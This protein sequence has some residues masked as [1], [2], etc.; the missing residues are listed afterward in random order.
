MKQLTTNSPFVF[1]GW[2]DEPLKAVKIQI[3]AGGH[4]RK[5]KGVTLL[6]LSCVNSEL[7]LYN[8]RRTRLISL[9]FYAL[10][11]QCCSFYTCFSQILNLRP[12]GQTATKPEPLFEVSFP[13]ENRSQFNFWMSWSHFFVCQPNPIQF[14]FLFPLILQLRS[15]MR[16]Q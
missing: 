13:F 12:S 16:L 10:L 1:T 3:Q 9:P 6:L 8:D 7:Q 15:I 14:L 5:Q 11:K 2:L 4:C